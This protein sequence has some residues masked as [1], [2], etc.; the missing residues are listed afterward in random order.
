MTSEE[1]RFS[2]EE[3][4]LIIRAAQEL[5]ER[6]EAAAGAGSGAD[7]GTTPGGALRPA[8]RPE[9]MSLDEIEAVATEVGVDIASVRRAAAMLTADRPVVRS[10]RLLGGP[11]TF[12]YRST[13][14]GRVDPSDLLRVA[15]TIRHATGH[16][17]ETKEILNSLEW[18]TSAGESTRISVSVIPAR[19]ETVVS[20][21]ADR[22][23]S[24][25]LCYIFS[26][27]PWVIAAVAIGDTVD[28][29][30]VGGLAIMGGGLTGGYVTARTIW[31]AA[32][33]SF[34]KKMR[35][36][37]TGLMGETSALTK[38]AESSAEDS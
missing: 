18:T 22:Q 34:M 1:R 4:A 29:G 11:T 8:G 3:F 9:G 35:R 5:Q 28:P 13:L 21:V 12:T 23:T 10:N 16:S 14:P 19:D 36:L 25:L 31:T 33:R 24:A 32:T 7:G 2:D 20:V 26:T 38:T 30:I 17:G 6:S 15:D 27:M 37:T